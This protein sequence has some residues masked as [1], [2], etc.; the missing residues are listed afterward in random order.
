METNMSK[1]RSKTHAHVIVS[2][3]AYVSSGNWEVY[4]PGTRTFSIAQGTC[5]PRIN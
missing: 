1:L 5:G 4:T 3:R 2:T